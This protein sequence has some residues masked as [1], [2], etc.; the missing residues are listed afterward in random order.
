MVLLSCCGRSTY[1]EDI[2]EDFD[3]GYCNFM[4]CVLFNVPEG[5]LA[6]M[7][8]RWY[9]ATRFPAPPPYLEHATIFVLE[10]PAF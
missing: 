10:N 7:S 1:Y 8:P 2:Q 4:L 6:Q 5:V 9:R 3:V